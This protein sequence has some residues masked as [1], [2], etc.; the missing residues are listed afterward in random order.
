MSRPKPYRDSYVCCKQVPQTGEAN[1]P[2]TL[3][4]ALRDFRYAQLLYELRPNERSRAHLRHA[5]EYAEMV[6]DKFAA[7]ETDIFSTYLP[8]CEPLPQKERAA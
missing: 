4:T 5:G 3:A 6:L 2:Q 7:A 8:G 1:D